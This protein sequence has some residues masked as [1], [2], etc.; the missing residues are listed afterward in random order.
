M[1]KMKLPE[2]PPDQP[3]ARY[4]YQRRTQRLLD[5]QTK[6]LRQQAT[7]EDMAYFNAHA[8]PE[9]VQQEIKRML[10]RAAGLK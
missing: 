3:E 5:I 4:W 9:V 8:A 7:P 1:V 10:R 6:I 2:P